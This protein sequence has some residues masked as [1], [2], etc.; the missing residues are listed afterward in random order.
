MAVRSPTP[1]SPTSRKTACHLG[2]TMIEIVVAVAIVAVLAAGLVW[3]SYDSR[4]DRVEV[5]RRKLE[6]IRQKIESYKVKND[7]YPT[8]LNVTNGNTNGL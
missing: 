1:I 8:I 7:A 5:D 2:Y 4:A 3:L 6:L